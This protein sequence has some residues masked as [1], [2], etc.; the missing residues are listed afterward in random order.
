MWLRDSLAFDL[1]GIRILVYGFD[2]HLSKSDSFQS[3]S[4]VADQFQDS[5]CAIRVGGPLETL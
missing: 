2:S 4:S 3:I 5:L 1:P